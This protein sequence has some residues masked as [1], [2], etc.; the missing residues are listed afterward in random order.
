MALISFRGLGT[1]GIWRD[2]EPY[3]LP[4]DAWSNGSNM[5]F[6][7]GKAMRSPIQRAIYAG[8]ANPPSFVAGLTPATG[9]DSV[10]VADNMGNLS[11]LLGGTLSPVSPTGFV[12]ASLTTPWTATMLGEVL[13]LNNPQFPPV[14]LAP[15]MSAFALVPTWGTQA[16]TTTPWSVRSLRAFQ[17]Y[18]VG[19]NWTMNG[20]ATP[21]LV[22]WSDL[23][24][25]GL[26][27]D[28]WDSTD[29]T[30]LAG[31][32][33]IGD[34]DS[35]FVD[36]CVLGNTLILYSQTQI[37]AMNAVAGE[38][39][40]AFQ[41][42]F[43]EGGLINQNC[44]VEANSAHYV[45]GTTDIYMHDG[46]V[47]E[48]ILQ[49]LNRRFIYNSMDMTNAGAC[50][51]MHM[52]QYKEILFAFPSGDPYAYFPMGSGC[53]RGFV[54]NYGDSTQSLIDLPNVVAGCL[55][56]M[57]PIQTWAGSLTAGT[58]WQEA[59]SSWLQQDSGAVKHIVLASAAN[60]A[61]PAITENRV[62]GYDYYDNGQLAYPY[63]AE[64]SAPAWIERV[65]IDLEAE[66]AQFPMYKMV[67]RVFPRVAISTPGVDFTVQV[68]ASL[69]S[70]AP[71]VW[72]PTF[73]F[74]PSTDY[75]VDTRIGGRYLAFKMSTVAPTDFALTGLDID[76]HDGGSR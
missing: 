40:F 76:G 3:D 38:M 22:K 66:G 28:S 33:P 10:I 43:S 8:L 51:V 47:K 57:N 13:Y 17:N 18:L 34:L 42:L 44:V 35:P 2:P 1:K 9:F 59:G 56:S 48:S 53:N 21:D 61:A 70:G 14:Y 12:P 24:L 71:P 16:G 37:W 39:V 23:T 11:Q 20:V 75:K 29:P 55:A 46:A 19:V 50:F 60:T 25:A 67:D 41:R 32:N 63:V 4:L 6:S 27:P 26:P 5:R 62:L 31:A 7:A 64:C 69:V 74:D 52:P 45:F 36:S 54:Y 58:T 73:D 49:N 65:G 15:G 68:G 72:G 30:K